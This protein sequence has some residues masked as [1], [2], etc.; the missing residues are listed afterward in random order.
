VIN[1]N[2]SFLFYF[3][4][5]CTY[6]LLSLDAT[7]PYATPCLITAL[8]AQA[9]G[10][11]PGGGGGY[12]DGYI[13]QVEILFNTAKSAAQILD[14]ATLVAHYTFDC[15]SYPA[16]DSGPNQMPAVAVS[17]ISGDGGRVGQSYLFNSLSAYFQI[18]GLILIGQ[19]YSL[20]SFAMWL[21]P[22]SV[23]SGGTILHISQYPAGTGWC[24][25]FIG[26][27]SSG[28]IVLNGWNG[29]LIQ[30]IG[31]ILTNG[32]WVHIAH[33][34]SQTYGLSLYV[35]GVLYGRSGAFN[36]A[37]SG[38]S[39][40]ATLG[41]SMGVTGC[42]HSASVPGSYQ[43]EIDEFYIYSRELAQSDVTALA[44]A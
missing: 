28:Q 11:Y 40:T 42:A 8:G 30:L 13:D 15:I 27:S 23:T 25:P 19:S 1:K 21:R 37:A 33:T 43:G 41:Q 24:I 18:S 34:Y 31:P 29:G 44:N 12:F 3:E 16:W 7:N 6:Y 26:L 5:R 32:Q 2:Y 22:I 20:F 36:F 4:I 17:L 39:M 9:I 10:A 14:D 35:N 38:V